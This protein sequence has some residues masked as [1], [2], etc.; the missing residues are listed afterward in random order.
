MTV[1]LKMFPFGSV[2]RHS[3]RFYLSLDAVKMPSS[4]S[5]AEIKYELAHI[6]ESRAPNIVISSTICISLAIT[7][8]I[9][10]LLA[11]RLSKVKILADDY[12]MIFALVS[13]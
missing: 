3:A 7:A 1:Y 13:R 11:R 8:V 9:L 4:L 2:P 12:M 10:R 5:P 6:H